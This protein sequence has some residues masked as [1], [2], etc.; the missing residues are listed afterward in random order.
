MKLQL[1][2]LLG[3]LLGSALSPL[4]A[5]TATIDAQHVLRVHF[6]MPSTPAPVPDVLELLF[7]I[8]QV[9]AAHG[10]RT[11]KL[12]NCD[13]LLGTATT[14]SFGGYVGPLSLSPANSWRQ[15][16]SM[17]NF[18]NPG[19]VA[20]FSSLQ[21]A[22]IQGIID[23]TVASGSFTLN[24]SN[25]SLLLIRATSAS[26]GSVCN[27][28]PQIQEVT[29]VPLLSGPTPGTVGSLNTWSTVGN[30]PGN[31]VFYAFGFNCAPQLVPVA[32]PVWFDIQLP[33][34]TFLTF[35]TPTGDTQFGFTVPP[36]ASGISLLTQCVE[37]GGN[38]IKVTNFVRH[39]F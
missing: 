3:A 4:C 19:D 26:G 9:S 18:D 33:V 21:N 29:V 7:G 31:P 24:L 22:S 5:Q 32:P 10:S 23:F 15:T 16:G 17:W 30:T 28:Q 8:V 20:D 14:S 25:V 38:D 39:T 13:T 36:S 37:L 6:T 35:A 34:V 1:P 2:V 12:Y 11:A 27:P